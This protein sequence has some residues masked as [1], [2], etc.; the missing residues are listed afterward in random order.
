MSDGIVLGPLADRTTAK[1]AGLWR[2]LTTR[3]QTWMVVPH[4]QAK[5]HIACVGTTGSGKTEL[6][7]RYF[8]GMLDYEWRAFVQWK[9]VPA[10]RAKHPR[11]LIAVISC[12]GGQDDRDLGIEIRDYAVRKGIE[13]ARIAN[14]MPGGDRLNLFDQSARDQRAAFA[15][16][17]NAGEATTSEG[18]HFDEMRR[19]IV[20]LVIDAPVGPPRS[21]QEFLQRL[22][23]DVLVDIWGQAPDVKRMVLS[24]IHI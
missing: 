24:L 14:V 7:K 1:P 10:M 19:R 6:I 4:K 22:D 9:D 3:H 20:S 16:M 13:P 23:A 17:L 8:V 12:K 21:S 5:R 11:P 18:Q 2:E 15:D